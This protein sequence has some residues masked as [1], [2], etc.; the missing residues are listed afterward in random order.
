[1]R[2]TAAF[3]VL[4]LGFCSVAWGAESPVA[5]SPGDEKGAL[6]E[7]RCPTFSWGE[8]EGAKS[9]DL[10]VYR[11]GEE[12]EDEKPVLRR[13]FPGSVDGWTPAL[14]QCLERGGQYAWSV[15]A[16]GGKG[17]SEWSAPSLFEVA[18]GPSEEEFEEAVQV[19]RQY[20]AEEPTGSVGA[21]ASSGVERTGS[22]PSAP[23]VSGVPAPNAASSGGDAAL[24]VNGS[25]VVTVATFLSAQC[26]ALGGLRYWDRGDGTVV[27]C[28][29]GLIW[30][31]D[32]SCAE[33]AGTDLEGQAVWGSALFAA[34]SLN[35]GECGLTDG[36]SQLDWRLPTASEFCSL[37]QGGSL[38]P[39]P[40]GAASD[41]LINSSVAGSPKV[42]NEYGDAKWSEGRAFSGVDNSPYWTA[43][44]TGGGAFM[45]DLFQG[46]IQF[47]DI[48]SNFHVWPVRGGQ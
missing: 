44:Q 29:T 47:F 13:S 24:Q 36:S 31:K 19:V 32:A 3:T 20:L 48:S 11:V 5:V 25:P 28:N 16:V 12:N 40:A 6:I 42:A 14:D 9:Y 35:D 45:A 7:G 15:R 43:N 37:F 41:S 22:S 23:K 27:D 21:L 4:V 1:M 26:A 18:S 8:V 17:A 39:C 33:L 34:E 46:N 2:R 30:L 38:A 10:I